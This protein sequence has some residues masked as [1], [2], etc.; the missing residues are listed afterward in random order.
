LSPFEGV[1]SCGDAVDANGSDGS[2][3]DQGRCELGS[4]FNR[5]GFP[6]DH[7]NWGN[8]QNFKQCDGDWAG[9]DG[10]GNRIKLP[11]SFGLP[12]GPSRDGFVNGD[13]L[14][15]IR[16]TASFIGVRDTVIVAVNS[17]GTFSSNVDL[18]ISW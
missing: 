9:S 5:Q 2:G 12:C 4:S 18:E 16:G 7:G 17:G 14:P 1:T 8:T 15:L 3:F 11:F 6:I 13:T 10:T